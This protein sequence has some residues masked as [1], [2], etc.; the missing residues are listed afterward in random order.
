MPVLLRSDTT[1][2]T[3]IGRIHF[4]AYHSGII[5]GIPDEDHWFVRAYMHGDKILSEGYTKA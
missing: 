4:R 2:P 3:F 5:K 1:W